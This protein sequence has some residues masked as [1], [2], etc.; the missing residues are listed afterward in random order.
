MAIREVGYQHRDNSPPG[1]TAPLAAATFCAAAT[2]A[3]AAQ[4][5]SRMA[6]TD[7]ADGS[8]LLVMLGLVCGCFTM[9]FVSLFVKSFWVCF[10]LGTK[11]C[12]IYFNS[13]SFLS[14]QANTSPSKLAGY[15]PLVR[16]KTTKQ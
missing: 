4:A 3:S 7:A 5:L 6:D 11:L 8:L 9:F 15:R 10:Y 13:K 1:K 2:L 12:I 14:N 16:Q